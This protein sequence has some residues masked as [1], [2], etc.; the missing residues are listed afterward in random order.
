MMMPVGTSETY[1][2]FYETTLRDIPED[3]Q[4]PSAFETQ[5]S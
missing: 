2:N 3:N 1:I 5:S 4:S